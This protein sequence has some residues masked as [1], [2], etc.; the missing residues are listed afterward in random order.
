MGV[1]DQRH[2]LAA[3][4]PGKKR[5]PLYRELGGPQD[6]YGWVRKISARPEFNPQAAQPVA[7]RY[8]DYVIP[9][10]FTARCIYNSR[11]GIMYKASVRRCIFNWYF[12]KGVTATFFVCFHILGRLFRT[13]GDS[14][15]PTEYNRTFEL[16]IIELRST[17]DSSKSNVRF[18]L[19][20]HIVEFGFV[21]FS[22]EKSCGI[23][24]LRIVVVNPQLQSLKQ[25][26]H[27][28]IRSSKC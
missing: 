4:P 20:G 7:S 27:N 8:A 23:L 10:H 26:G 2:V 9:A 25:F 24:T 11:W 18:C 19:Y 22:T 16:P 6:R 13:T 15:Q 12:M 5:Y 3:L 28:D 1:A 17:L 14:R 21:L